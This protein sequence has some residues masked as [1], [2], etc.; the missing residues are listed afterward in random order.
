[1]N[2]PRPDDLTT[3][4][5]RIIIR[6]L[7]YLADHDFNRISDISRADP[8]DVARQARHRAEVKAVAGKIQRLFLA[9]EDSTS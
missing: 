2:T 3:A 5:S 4:E 6:A 8:E 1:M 7:H 9:G